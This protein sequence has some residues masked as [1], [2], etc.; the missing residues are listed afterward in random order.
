MLGLC[1]KEMTQKKTNVRLEDC[2][3]ATCQ[4]CVALTFDQPE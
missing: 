3:G 2:P 4:A 1:V